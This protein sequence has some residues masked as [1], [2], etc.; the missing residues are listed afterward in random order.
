MARFQWKWINNANLCLRLICATFCRVLHDHQIS[1]L[2]IAGICIWLLNFIIKL[3]LQSN[4]SEIIIL[5]SNYTS[6]FK[7]FS[8]ASSLKLIFILKRKYYIQIP[9][10]LQTTFRSGNESS[11][12]ETH[13]WLRFYSIL[14]GVKAY[15]LNDVDPQ[16]C[17]NSRQL[18]YKP[19]ISLPYTI[20]NPVYGY[21]SPLW[22]AY[23]LD[24]KNKI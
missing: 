8:Y 6:K 22:H 2:A 20:K 16:I 1:E 3:T 19:F 10:L 4:F 9:I 13:L 14:L 5:L 24:Y 21:H 11:F 15:I 23:S 7:S 17:V 12:Y 18:F